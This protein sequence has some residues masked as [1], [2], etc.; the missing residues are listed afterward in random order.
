MVK[1]STSK[2][3]DGKKNIARI[4]KDGSIIIPEKIRES[5]GIEPGDFLQI[6][7]LGKGDLQFIKVEYKTIKIPKPLYDQ[8]AE[9]AN[10]ENVLVEDFV[11]SAI[12]VHL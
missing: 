9:I 2:E 1:S 5:L 4:E 11:N 6:K 12:Q 8:V 3:K 7:D 10:K